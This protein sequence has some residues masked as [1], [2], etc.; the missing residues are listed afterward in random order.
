MR[1]MRQL[2]TLI[3][4]CFTV[5]A[6]SFADDYDFSADEKRMIDWIDA[7]QTQ[8]IKLL[9]E[10]VNI[11]SGTM[12]HDG[13][14]A[15]GKVMSRE[16]ETLGMETRWIDM[17]PSIDR[18]GHLFASKTG[19]GKRFLLI[20]H[21][22]TVFESDDEFQ[23]FTLEGNVGRGPGIS[24][25][26]DGN[27]VIVY[28][29]KAL[30]HIGALDD[31][32]VT[33]AFTGDEEM[34]GRPLSISRKDLIDAGKWADYALGFEGAITTEGSDWATIARRSSSSWTLKTTGK[35]A[36]SS[37]V[38]SQGVG[39][40]AINEAARILNSFYEEVRGD[41]GLTFNA[42]TIQGGTT[43]TFDSTQK[44]GSTFGK[45]NVVPSQA[46]IN[47]G[48]RALSAEQL[49]EAKAKM[50]AIVS[51][52]LPH[53]TS[54][55]T[56]D[57]SYPPMPPTAGNQRLADQLSA[58]NR[59]LGRGP[60]KIWDPLRRGAADISF[61]APYTDALAGMGALGKGGHTPNESLELDSMS[62][63]IKRAA[64]LIY[65]LS[66]EADAT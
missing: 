65:R 53:T 49:A 8:V 14:K 44:R 34:A 24:D 66:R 2:T 36:H 35:Q 38:F 58:I 60:M 30:Q 51:R 55:I 20:G 18:A 1:F 10:T 64:I 62:L 56:F 12:N 43:V 40:G 42:G 6:S 45:T 23:A 52:H 15:V 57:D 59:A 54:S 9:E 7:H 28:A 27:A 33:V 29:L 11:G 25:M 3:A 4:L 16:L 21:L 22:D 48:I 63:A 39:A 13:V 17:P 47:G 32:A 50:R 31:L 19:Q 37:A 41:Y 61:V 5:S 26:K 46:I